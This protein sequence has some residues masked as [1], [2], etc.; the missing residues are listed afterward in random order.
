MKLH[1]M[2]KEMNTQYHFANTTVVLML[3]TMWKRCIWGISGKHMKKETSRGLILAVSHLL[4]AAAH[5]WQS[6]V[7]PASEEQ[8]TKLDW[9]AHTWPANFSAS[10]PSVKGSLQPHRKQLYKKSKY[11]PAGPETEPIL[12]KAAEPHESSIWHGRNIQN[13]KYY[14]IL[15]VFNGEMLS[16]YEYSKLVHDWLD[17]G[18]DHCV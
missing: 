8:S 2:T 3:K 17:F 1:E 18:H 4:G 7:A 5:L 13:Q 6:M 11:S 15:M 12:G 9:K 16:S 14:S 10:G